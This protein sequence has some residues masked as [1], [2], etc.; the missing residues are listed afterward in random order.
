MVCDNPGPICF[1]NQILK[2]K[3]YIVWKLIGSVFDLIEGGIQLAVFLGDILLYP[4]IIVIFIVW[5]VDY[6]CH[7]HLISAHN[8]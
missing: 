1:Y 2:K 5:C 3:I 8:C 6:G 7:Q 4:I